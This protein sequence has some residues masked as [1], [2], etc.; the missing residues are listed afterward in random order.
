MELIAATG[1]GLT[2]NVTGIDVAAFGA[3]FETVIGNIPVAVNN[4]AGIEV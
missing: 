3:G 2:V 1:T 4:E